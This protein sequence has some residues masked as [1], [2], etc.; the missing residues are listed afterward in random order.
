M[1][2]HMLIG[3]DLVNEGRMHPSGHG[4]VV[5]RRRLARSPGATAILD[6]HEACRSPP[7]PG[8]A[9]SSRLVPAQINY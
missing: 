9:S 7:A 2:R 5:S 6:G 1:R 8:R 4:V 3:E